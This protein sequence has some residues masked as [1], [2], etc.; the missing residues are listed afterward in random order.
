MCNG[1]VFSG[2]GVKAIAYIGV[3]KALEE[4]NIYFEKIAGTSAGSIIAS[5]YACGFTSIEMKE[6]VLKNINKIK[7]FDISSFFTIAQNVLSFNIDKI[8]G[9][10]NGK[11]L[12]NI[13]YDTFIQKGIYNISQVPKDLII[14]SVNITNDKLYIFYSK[15]IKN[16]SRKNI[17]Y[18]NNI[19]LSKCILASSSFPGVFGPTKIEDEFFVD[20]G[21]IENIPWKEL[22]NIGVNKI[23]NLCFEEI[24][25]ESCIDKNKKIDNMFD[26]LQKSFKILS[27]K[28]K[29]YEMY[30]AE[31]VLNIKLPKMK[32]LEKIN[33]EHLIEEGYRQAKEQIEEIKF[34]I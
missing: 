4:E 20:G 31:Y 8:L 15:D 10:N 7:Y 16:F 23:F 14:P 5:M 28:F 6:V 9:L 3:I 22:K 2:G 25:D 11:K 34:F 1:I 24:C 29:E 33:V 17:I 21:V 30:G 26:V 18:K 13:L 27:D 12:Y 32:L 19:S